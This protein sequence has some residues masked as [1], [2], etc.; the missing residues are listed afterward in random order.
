MSRT[1]KYLRYIF[2]RI[3]SQPVG[4]KQIDSTAVTYNMWEIYRSMQTYDSTLH[5]ESAD[6]TTKHLRHQ[7]GVIR[8]LK[9]EVCYYFSINTLLL[10][11]ICAGFQ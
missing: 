5:T 3:G 4:K 7:L 1:F 6:L 9:S 2:A 11:C 10:K 8:M